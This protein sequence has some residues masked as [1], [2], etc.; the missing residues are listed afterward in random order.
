MAKTSKYAAVL[1]K[2]K[3][4]NIKNVVLLESSSGNIYFGR[5][6]KIDKALAYCPEEMAFLRAIADEGAHLRINKI[7][8]FV[9]G[10]TLSREPVPCL[11]CRQVLNNYIPSVV[12]ICF[13][14][15]RSP[16]RIR[17]FCVKKN[18]FYPQ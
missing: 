4:A 6:L 11:K 10:Q 1:K 18:D 2:H 17:E 13:I 7:L 16:A 5:G 3:G 15:S 14:N 12:K 8:Y 9:N